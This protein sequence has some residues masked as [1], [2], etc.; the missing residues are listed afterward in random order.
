MGR[1]TPSGLVLLVGALA[2]VSA[3]KKGCGSGSAEPRTTPSAFREPVIGKLTDAGFAVGKMEETAADDYGAE[4]CVRGEVD[5]LEVLLCDYATAEAAKENRSKLVSFG[6]GAVSGATRTS[7]TT[8]IVVADR[9][10]ADLAGKRMKRLLD[11][12]SAEPKA[13][14]SAR[15]SRV[16]ASK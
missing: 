4:E 1:L 7:G 14:K 8:A 13:T 5:R 11:T 3:C 15:R 16:A 12:F 6:R 9:Q 2:A 10:N